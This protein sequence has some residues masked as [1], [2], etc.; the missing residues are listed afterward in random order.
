MTYTQPLWT[1][2]EIAKGVGE[3]AAG[4]WVAEG[5]AVDSRE[6]VPGDL[7]VALP[8]SL[9][10]GHDFVARALAAGAAG[11]LVER[12]P[13]GV[14]E[15]DPRLIRVESTQAA[16]R[17]LGAA[18]R[19]RMTGKV[20]AVTGSVG[21]TSVKDALKQ[22]LGRSAA[23]HAG[24]RSFNNHVGL[25]L[26]LAR[27]P[28]DARYGIFE[29]GM[30]A[31]GEIAPLSELVRPDVAVITTVGA[32][33]AGAFAS[34]AEIAEE[35]AGIFAGLAPGGTAILNIDHPHAAL[36]RDRAG[37]AGAE[38][39]TVSM[40]DETAD[41]HPLRLVLHD[42][43]S[44]L[45]ARL[46]EQVAAIKVGVP[47]R[48][49][50]MNA[51]LVLAAARAAGGD[52]ALAGLALG[53]LRIPDG[54]GTRHWVPVPGGSVRLI[55]DAYNANPLSMAA[56]FASLRACRPE[57]GGRRIAVLADMAELGERSRQLHLDLAASLKAA[58]VAEVI[59]IGE[60]TRAM[61]DAAGIPA[62]ACA[63]I[64][65]ALERLRH[66]LRPGDVVLVKG[67]N[68]AGLGQ[69]VASL[70]AGG[71]GPRTRFPDIQAA[72]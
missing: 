9:H 65:T 31:P 33:H 46:G 40:T 8:G 3:R 44:C 49:W 30:N 32:A 67:A 72:E 64:A 11:A 19:E 39:V 6:V 58:E 22:A 4:R 13:Q 36:L 69:L 2:D 42:E 63:D 18:A 50:V 37:Q 26:S 47:G 54:R 60:H 25:P 23:S 48:H 71:V 7:F 34:E 21:K 5:V 41:V 59:A 27:M 28:R 45:T 17:A 43:V 57:P 55:D 56:A 66:N 35:K 15:D 51:L 20:I 61:A 53:D 29:L 12:S 10:D 62:T 68:R 16:L 24:L 38:I 1:S 52:L 14:V 70:R